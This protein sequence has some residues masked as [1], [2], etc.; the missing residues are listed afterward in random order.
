[1]YRRAHVYLKE[2][3]SKS[4]A[5]PLVLRGARQVGKS[6]LVKSFC[7]VEGYHECRINLEEIKFKSLDLP[8]IDVQRFLE[9]VE[10]ET[11]HNLN[12]PKTI[13]F[14]DEIQAQPNALK[15]LRYLYEQR[16]GLK[17]IS[18]GSLLEFA[19]SDIEY[20]APVGRINYFHLGPM[21]FSEFLLALN[22]TSLSEKLKNPFRISELAHEKLSR[23]YKYYLFI[24]GM[25]EAVKTYSE[26]KSLLQV[27]EVH[28]SLLE[29]YRDDFLKYTKN[30]SYE[31][32]HK[33]FDYVP[34]SLGKKIRYSEIDRDEKSRDLKRAVELLINARILMPVFH[35]QGTKSPIKAL[36]DEDIFKLYFVDVGLAA[37]INRISWDQIQSDNGE[38]LL[39][40]GQLHE[41]FIAQHLW[42]RENGLLTPDLY[43]WLRDRSSAKAEVDFI[44]DNEQKPLPI[45][46]KT[47]GGRMKSLF[48]FMAEKKLKKALKFGNTFPSKNNVTYKIKNKETPTTVNFELISLPHYCVEW[49][50][51]AEAKTP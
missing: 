31:R 12:D 19:L 24:G 28:R 45:E 8:D 5:K 7:A 38:E 32:V 35:T 30:S 27:M 17:I 9:E 13:L 48:V 15:Y 29:T 26:T 40:L 42:Y 20:S 3:F 46:V 37:S 43:Y 41:Q 47:Q 39:L 1:M 22:E 2:Y 18:A 34:T 36:R 51:T 44:I 6:T 25:P 10:L 49:L 33:I 14:I 21:S 11:R 23:F 16:P 50:Y 4:Q